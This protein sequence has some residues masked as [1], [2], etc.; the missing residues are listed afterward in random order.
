MMKNKHDR[1]RTE[2][3]FGVNPIIEAI[4]AG[5]RKVFRIIYKEGSHTSAMARLL[6]LAQTKGIPTELATLERVAEMAGAEGHQGVA[7][8]VSPPVYVTLPPK[9]LGRCALKSPVV[10]YFTHARFSWRIASSS[11]SGHLSSPSRG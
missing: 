6:S 10:P 4:K 8:I 11:S 7:A 9:W 5:R 3:L 1:R 2:I